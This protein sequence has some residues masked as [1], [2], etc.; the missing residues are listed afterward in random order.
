MNKAKASCPASVSFIFSNRP[1]RNLTKMG[2]V[3][4][5][6]TIDKEVIVEA[7][8]SSVNEIIFNDAAI[9][10]P[11][12]GNVVD[13]L[14][15]TPV[16]VSIKSPLPLGYGFGISSASALAC[17]FALNKLF[18]LRKNRLELAKTAHIAEIK[19]YTGL[20]SVA[21]QITGGFLL[22]NK[23]GIPVDATSF[24]FVGKKLY[25]VIIDRLET[26]TILQ[27][28]SR[29]GKINFLADN[30]IDQIKKLKYVTLSKIVDISYKF[31][32]DDGLLVNDKVNSVIGEIHR[33]GAPATITMLGYV[34]MTAKKFDKI[35]N[36]E[37][38]ELTIT[39]DVVDYL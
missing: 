4:V 16:R 17:A 26:P 38:K 36:F 28:K 29:L 30:A 37:V 11:T 39:D 33:Q 1:N 8:K 2:S 7:E 10:F 5:G 31:A 12:V 22:K 25:V 13:S 19:N 24:P 32:K 27:D 3:G 14:A 20:G 6:C 15:Q 9:N 21:T 35:L 18:R 23:P 34:V